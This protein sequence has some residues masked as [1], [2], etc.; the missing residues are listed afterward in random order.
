MVTDNSKLFGPGGH[1][2]SKELSLISIKSPVP[3]PTQVIE[4]ITKLT[5]CT[6]IALP[7]FAEILTGKVA[8]DELDAIHNTLHKLLDIEDE[9]EIKE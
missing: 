4:N 6:V 9:K 2:I 5:G 8:K 7:P 3:I 1:P